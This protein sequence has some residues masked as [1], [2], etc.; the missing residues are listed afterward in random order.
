MTIRN[1]IIFPNLIF[2]IVLAILNTCETNIFYSDL[3]NAIAWLFR[4]DFKFQGDFM[5]KYEITLHDSVL[6]EYATIKSNDPFL[7]AQKKEKQLEKWKKEKTRIN[8]ENMASNM[9]E[10]A[11]MLQNDYKNILNHTLKT[12]DKID[13]EKMKDKSAFED[14]VIIGPGNKDSFFIDVPTKNFFEIFLPMLTRRRIRIENEAELKYQ[15][16]LAKFK[17]QNLERLAKYNQ[18]K[19]IFQN[20]QQTFNDGINSLKVSFETGQSEYICK[21]IEMVLEK[22]EYPQSIELDHELKYNKDSLTLKIKTFLPDMNN[23]NFITDVKYLKSKNEITKKYMP[24]KDMLLIYKSILNQLVLRTLHE[25]FESE[26][27]G[28][29]QEIEFEGVTRT[30]D[31]R[32]GVVKD[33]SIIN[34]KVERKNFLAINL[35]K[36]DH[37]ACLDSLGSVIDKKNLDHIFKAAA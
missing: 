29:I 17:E 3:P 6:L 23:L 25:I 30:T 1:V 31:P 2:L 19:S 35:A 27:I 21:Y 4:K 26:Y 20:N 36:V 34:L 28:H 22:S 33:F 8:Q 7:F 18:D 10:R 5:A 14:F 11:L 9:V 16:Y 12:D 13:W 24:K 15:D 37:E 32:I